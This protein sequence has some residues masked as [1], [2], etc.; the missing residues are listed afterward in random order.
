M[1]IYQ[2]AL[3]KTSPGVG[4]V[5]LKDVP[6]AECGEGRVRIE[7]SYTGIC[8]T[9]IHVFHDTFRNYP[10]VILGHE[11]S[12]VV[13]EVGPGVGMV[14]PGDVVTVMPSSAVVCGT[15]EYC[16]QGYYMFCPVRR[17]MGHGVNG[18][19]TRWVS[20]REDQVYKLPAGVSLE[21]GAMSEPF[22]AAVQAIEELTAFNVGD[23]V[24]LSGPGPIGLLCLLLLVAHKCKVIVAGSEPD[25]ERLELA[26]HLGADLTVDVS[27]EDLLEVIHRET[28]GKGVDVAVEAAGAVQSVVA[29]LHALRKLGRYVQVGIVGKEIAIPFDIILFKQVQMFGSVGH[30][31]RTWERVMKILE[32]RKID[33]KPLI[34]HI[35]PLSRWREG[36]DLCEQKK[37]MKVLLHYDQEWKKE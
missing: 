9:D 18:S 1:P 20:V 32:Q 33:L 14:Q 26:R 21:E 23:V 5:T 24:L 4:N 37:G 35:M 25:R 16:V 19:F 31:L 17:G 30:S 29:C 10:P 2:T 15:C 22:A 12:G 27:R 36:F 3:V 11:F 6:V 13:S 7:V 34:S 28:R 8:G